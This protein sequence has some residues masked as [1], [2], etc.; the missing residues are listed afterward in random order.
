MMMLTLEEI[1]KL[2]DAKVYGESSKE[3]I[4]INTLVNATSNQISHAVSQKYKKSLINS[5]AG[6]VII[7]KKL[8]DHCPSNALL[9]ENVPLAY[10][11]LT[12]EFKNHQNINHFQTASKVIKSFSK[13]N[14]APG[15][16]IGKN[17]TIGENTFIGA[18]CVIEDDVTIGM[19]SLIE[20]NVT[21]HKG[22]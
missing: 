8:I 17:V 21:I 13:V 1:A 18:N 19:N 6:A 14:I 11:L 16:I 9:V 7:D 12:H 3:I 4:G 2:I 15:C 20:S 22:M 10:A 5:N